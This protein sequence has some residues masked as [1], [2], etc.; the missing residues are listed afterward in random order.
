MSAQDRKISAAA[1]SEA[2]LPLKQL[3]VKLA[4][5]Q[6][7]DGSFLARAKYLSLQLCLKCKEETDFAPE[8]HGSWVVVFH[9]FGERNNSQTGISLI[10]VSARRGLDSS[11]NYSLACFHPPSFQTFIMF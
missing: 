11:I 10:F 9:R 4:K 2:G 1:L 3:L 7:S 8:L 5:S 6:Q